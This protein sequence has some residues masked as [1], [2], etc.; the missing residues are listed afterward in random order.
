M[1]KEIDFDDIEIKS[2]Q[3]IEL[4]DELEIPLLASRGMVV[5]PHMVIPLL[6]GRDKSIEAIEE[7]MVA[8]KKILIAT[9]KDEKIENPSEDDIYKV[10]TVAEVKQLVKLP[11]WMIKVIVE[12]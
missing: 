4:E 9:Q 7:A 10:G 6:V 2:E 1:A 3:D 5:F 8:D 12:G 11:N